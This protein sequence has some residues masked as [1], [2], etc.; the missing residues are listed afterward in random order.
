MKAGEDGSAL[1]L[2]WAGLAL[3][4]VALVLVVD[5]AAYQAA[6]LRAQGVADAAALAAVAAGHPRTTDAADGPG[7]A[8]RVARAGGADLVACRCDRG[9]RT[10][11]VTVAVPV[12][13]VALTRFAGRVVRATAEARLVPTPQPSSAAQ[14]TVSDAG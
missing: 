1:A 5:L 6:A 3:A 9:A 7:R 4:V 12:R 13:A 14:R 8:A 10:V 2:S 11:E